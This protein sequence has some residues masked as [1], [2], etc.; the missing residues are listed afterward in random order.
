MPYPCRFDAQRNQ[1]G[2][3][4]PTPDPCVFRRTRSPRV[5]CGRMLVVSASVVHTEGLPS[6][7]GRLPCR[8]LLYIHI[9]THS[10][11]N[12]MVYIYPPHMYI[13]PCVSICLPRMGIYTFTRHRGS[14]QED[15]LEST[16]RYLP[17]K[18]S[19]SELRISNRRRVTETQ[20]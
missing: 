4:E 16:A 18:L 9:R 10:I 6:A 14:H 8:S 11:Y 3:R 1:S 12:R 20:H 19:T 13:Y 15:R 5:T 7:S 2:C 17:Q